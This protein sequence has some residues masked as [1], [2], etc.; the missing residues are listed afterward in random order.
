M[1]ERNSILILRS[2]VCVLKIS[3]SGGIKDCFATTATVVDDCGRYD[4]ATDYNDDYGVANNVPWSGC[5]FEAT[6]R[7][8]QPRSE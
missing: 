5:E 7:M 4:Y 1:R 3:R 6:E 8:C 2:D